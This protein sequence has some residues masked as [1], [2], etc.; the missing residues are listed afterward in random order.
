MESVYVQPDIR[1]Y[2]VQVCKY[3]Q[4]Q[5]NAPR[6]IDKYQTPYLCLRLRV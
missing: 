4:E 5:G 2:G 1:I 6:R 3:C